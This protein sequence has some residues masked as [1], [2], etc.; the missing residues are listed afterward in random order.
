MAAFERAGWAVLRTKGSHVIMGKS[1]RRERLSV[2]SHRELREG[3][4][5]SLLRKAGLSVEEFGN[6][7]A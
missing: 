6:L 1:G 3:T 2:P 4:L 7:L 5:R